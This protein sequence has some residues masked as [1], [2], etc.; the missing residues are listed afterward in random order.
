M[1][2]KLSVELAQDVV[3]CLF[4]EEDGVDNILGHPTVAWLTIRLEAPHLNT[5]SADARV[6]ISRIAPVQRSVLH[7]IHLTVLDEGIN[8]D[9][10]DLRVLL[11]G[12]ED[13]GNVNGQF[14]LLGGELQQRKQPGSARGSKKATMLQTYLDEQV[15]QQDDVAQAI[16]G[17]ATE[18]VVT[19]AG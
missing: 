11:I 15:G 9:T 18:Q 19:L 3:H 5:T 4:A 12:D 10:F 13:S 14:R 17:T 2:A 16:S 7:G 6:A 1:G 8:S